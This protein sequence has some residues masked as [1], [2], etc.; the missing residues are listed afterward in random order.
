MT[1]TDIFLFVERGF[2]VELVCVLCIVLFYF[3]IKIYLWLHGKIIKRQ[4]KIIHSYMQAENLFSKSS[5]LANKKLSFFKR[6]V[7][8]FIECLGEMDNKSLTLNPQIVLK[9]LNPAAKKF[10]R[11][12]NWLKN[13]FATQCLSYGFQ[14]ADEVSV[15]KLVKS[16]RLIVS[17]NAAKLV[18]KYPTQKTVNALIEVFNNGRALNRSLCIEILANVKS[19][20]ISMLSKYIKNELNN[21]SCD[22][23]PSCYKR[24]FCYQLLS[25]INSPSLEFATIKKDIEANT[26]DLAIAAMRYLAKQAQYHSKAVAILTKELHTASWQIKSVACKLLGEMHAI[27]AAC[28]LEALLEDEVWWVRYNAAFSLSQLGSKGI[29]ILKKQSAAKK[30]AYSVAKRV[31]G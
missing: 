13:Y 23:T 7:G 15:V 10:A 19:A 22:D 31:L 21:I 4:K 14:A 11:S 12:H 6:H 29:S 24:L 2:Y 5:N 27:E 1:M 18:F 26:L 30:L 17:L 8:L 3:L 20:K 25:I 28:H 9:C 16:E